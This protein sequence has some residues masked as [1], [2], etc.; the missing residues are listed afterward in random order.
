MRASR[1]KLQ[2]LFVAADGEPSPAKARCDFGRR[3]K[4]PVR[5]DSRLRVKG[6]DL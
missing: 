1:N 2:A 3:N 6:N 4:D 5:I